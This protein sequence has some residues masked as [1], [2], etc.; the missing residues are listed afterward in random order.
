MLV[1]DNEQVRSKQIEK[2]RLVRLYSL[3]L[4]HIISILILRIALIKVKESRDDVRA[5]QC[6]L[7]LTQCAS[8]EDGN[9]LAL[10]VDAALA[11]CTVG[12]ITQ[13]MEKASFYPFFFN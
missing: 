7:A 3:F 12:E 11:R 8:G 10:A 4:L 1:I 13:A 6:L 2:I 5:E 9:L